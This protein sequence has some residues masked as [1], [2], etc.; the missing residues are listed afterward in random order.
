MENVK[1]ESAKKFF[2][3]ALCLALCILSLLPV[4]TFGSNAEDSIEG[5][6]FTA[7]DVADP[8]MVLN[9]Y[10]EMP[11]AFAATV[12]FDGGVD[13]ASPIISNL[14]SYTIRHR[15]FE[16]TP[17]GN[18]AISSYYKY[19]GTQRY[20]YIEKSSYVEFDYSII[21]LGEVHL[22]VVDEI[23][24]GKSVYKLYVN[25][26]LVD[27]V[28]K[29]PYVYDQ[30]MYILQRTRP[31][32][33][34]CDAKNYF[35]GVIKNVAVYSEALTAEEVASVFANGADT[36][37]SDIMAYYDLTSSD[38]TDRF[39]KDQTGN[40]HYASDLFGNSKYSADDYAYSIAVI[41]DT[42]SLTIKDVND[43]TDYTSYIYEWI[44]RNKDAK[45]IQFVMGL[46]DVTDENLS[47]E[48]Q[49]VAD[50]HNKLE[51][52]NLPYSVIQGNHDTV[53]QLDKFFKDKDNFTQAVE[54]G[55]IGYFSEDSLANYY[56]TFT[57]TDKEG[58]ATN[59]KYL[60]LNLECKVPDEVIPWAN[61]VIEQHSEYQVIINTHEYVQFPN[62]YFLHI[63]PTVEEGVANDPYQ[64]WSKLASQH[65]NV[66]MVLSGHLSIPTI[67]MKNP[68][69]GVN[70]NTV[71]EFLI[72]PQTFDI[73][74]NYETG[75]IA[76]FY[77]S[78]DGKTVKTEYVSAY[79]SLKADELDPSAPDVISN[80]YMSN[81]TLDIGKKVTLSDVECEYGTIPA[82]Y[83]NAETYP[84]VIFKPDK[85]FVGGYLDFGDVVKAMVEIDASADY[86][87]LMRRNAEQ[88]YSSDVSELRGNI[89]IDLGGFILVKC[90]SGY[91]IN[92]SVSDNSG[93]VGDDVRGSFKI[94]N[95]TINKCA[96]EALVCVDYGTADTG[97]SKTF[98]TTIDFEKV[99]IAKYSRDKG[100]NLV[101]DTKE[102]GYSNTTGDACAIV[103]STF[104][105]CTFDFRLANV[106]CE[107]LQLSSTNGDRIVYNVKIV[108]SEIVSTVGLSFSDFA[109]VD[110][111]TNG[112]A[113][114]VVFAKNGDGEFFIQRLTSGAIA[115]G[116]V[117]LWYGDDGTPYVPGESG[118]VD[119]YKIYKLGGYTES[120]YGNVPDGNDGYAIWVFHNGSF[121]GGYNEFGGTSGAIAAAKTLTDGSVEDEIGSTVY[122]YF[123]DDAPASSSYAN[124]GQS[125]GNIVVDLD[126]HTLTQK[127]TGESLFNTQAKCYLGIMDPYSLTVING[128]IILTNK[129]VL[130]IDAYGEPY[131]NATAEYKEFTGKFENVNFSYA[132]GSA[133]TVF[134]G[135]YKNSAMAVPKKTMY[136]VD[137]TDCT[138]DF[139]NAASMATIMNINDSDTSNTDDI[140]KVNVYGSEI[141]TSNN[142]LVL[143]DVHPTNGSSV[144]WEASSE[145]NYL[146]MT[147]NGSTEAPTSEVNGGASAFAKAS[148]TESS[149][150]Y[151]LE[152]I[153]IQT[154]YGVLLNEH[155]DYVFAVFAE[156]VSIA[157]HNEFNR[158]SADCAMK[159]AKSKSEG[160]IEAQI[161]MLKNYE[162]HTGEYYSNLAQCKAKVTIDLNGYTFYAKSSKAMFQLHSKRD[163]ETTIYVVNGNVVLYN[164][165]LLEYQKYAI[166]G[167]II[168]MNFENV[169]FSLAEESTLTSMIA[170]NKTSTTTR[171][172]TLYVTWNITFTDCVFDVTNAASKITIFK[173]D[174]PTNDSKP[175]EINYVLEGCEIK[176]SSMDKFTTWGT[177]NANSSY[178]YG[179][180][181]TTGL[182]T[183]ITLPEGAAAPNPKEEIVIGGKSFGYAKESEATLDGTTYIT[184]A[185]GEMTKYGPIPPKF[186][187]VTSYPFVLFDQYGNCINSSNLLYGNTTV[188]S[189]IHI[190]KEYL[191][192][193]GSLYNAEDGTFCDG[194]IQ[195]FILMRCDYDLQSEN[196]YDHFSQIRGTVTIDLNGFT[197]NAR[198]DKVMV[199]A[200]A[201]AWG[202]ITTTEMVFKNGSIVTV[203]RPMLAYRGEF[204]SA[205]GKKF[206][207][208]YEDINFKVEGSTANFL[209]LYNGVKDGVTE[210]IK[211]SSE[212]YF[213]NCEIDITTATA[214]NILLFNL[215][216]EYTSTNVTLDGVTIKSDNGAFTLSGKTNEASTGILKCIG[217]GLM[218][219]LPI[220]VE[221]PTDDTYVFVE[222]TR[223]EGSVIYKAKLAEIEKL[224]FT[225]K[226]SITLGSELVYNIY[227]PVADYLK[228][229]TV[230]GATVENAEV[231]TLDDGNS[232]YRIE[233]SLPAKEAAR[234]I[235]L[236]AAVTAGGKDYTGTW[237]VSIPKYAAALLETN[238]SEEEKTLVKDVLQYIRAAYT[239]FGTED[240]EQ[241]AKIDT[242]L[243]DYASKPTVEGSDA[244][245][246]TGMKSA[247]L[248]LSGKPS[249]R[250]YL[251]DGAN[252][253]E[254]KFYIGGKQIKTVVSEDGTYVD[255]DVYAYELC[256]TVTYTVDGEDAG[257]FHINAYY[258][259]VS[260]TGENSYT[261]A[262]KEALTALTECFWKYL[263][264]ARAYRESVV[265]N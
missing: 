46:G 183:T 163:N 261:G 59:N 225:P 188:T 122:I 36:T 138:F 45:N 222:S 189:I 117:E 85:T 264:S 141:I 209:A 73:E 130:T 186:A 86:N 207:F 102:T 87:V 75:M 50:L 109:V 204:D 246:T 181:H 44:A 221:A 128:N 227:V 111:D 126:G 210:Q 147:V 34:G 140:I 223:D 155:A 198:D 172:E 5:R 160:G 214:E 157:G 241:I 129:G 236:K 149:V 240:A 185:L 28:T 162:A 33:I 232:Y 91:L 178:E 58:N 23:V 239:Y 251:A 233:V 94:M 22:V 97:L 118:T 35:S 64:I 100:T 146:Y 95:G 144:H 202:I 199:L 18:P 191:K 134:L 82:A 253:S 29:Y 124:L 7:D 17:E 237:T 247:T 57:A 12:R 84:F 187:S 229:F 228:S 56:M 16:I 105:D 255:I 116:A 170:T 174:Y 55:T 25:G 231:V 66:I 143:E 215:G 68:A 52:I 201:K 153:G 9:P 40:G 158:S 206:I 114:S 83:S 49:L 156:G 24:D 61:Q 211:M 81:Y 11:R 136:N 37:H 245:D 193:N 216:D 3:I 195:A 121:A 135:Y 165:A 48:W 103:N 252:A 161:L 177:F 53:K 137:F 217:N 171:D 26:E 70:G 88:Y 30:D 115:P 168:N 2:I 197:L 145:G 159:T 203:G 74:Q 213:K 77:F 234:N 67:S 79:K 194:A 101:F 60:V 133:A 226:T 148:E 250:F 173:A 169:N 180:S 10:T 47:T 71:Y 42:Q 260:G 248:V 62:S 96:G 190:T 106:P 98:T 166:D 152:Q 230:D 259:F 249:I 38:N 220:G 256:E 205:D 150:T 54:N 21:G 132:E 175:S 192:G 43:G 8:L 154:K 182:Y 258:A 125:V 113:D 196:K 80:P 218:L 20:E 176:A 262:D 112:R 263:Q 51:A 65:E 15:V 224:D 14:K 110:G 89:N 13:T 139:T 19:D 72:D 63:Y 219:E 69:V 212:V 257:S 6:A 179:V 31:Y 235:I 131:A 41:G 92:I 244:A 120:K 184:Y 39:I 265:E 119:G 107:A 167:K 208:R 4:F 93:V 127:Y 142:A 78:A 32:S 27:T 76:M 104:T 151:T 1:S 242:L 238:V 200:Y 90:S 99:V 254:Y 123:V 108:G 243:G 164:C